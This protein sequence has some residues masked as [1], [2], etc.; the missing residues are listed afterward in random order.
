MNI[1]KNQL[2]KGKLFCLKRDFCEVVRFLNAKSGRK[3]RFDFFSVF[4]SAAERLLD[5]DSTSSSFPSINN[6][7]NYNQ[8]KKS[9][10]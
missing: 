5:L 4:I 6:S 9:H 1:N 3:I 8:N 7:F 10:E 2:T